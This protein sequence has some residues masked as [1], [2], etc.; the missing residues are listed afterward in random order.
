MRGCGAL[1]S[2]K[3]QKNIIPNGR[4]GW[5]YIEAPPLETLRTRAGP[6]CGRHD[7]QVALTVV[8]FSS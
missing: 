3:N 5:A 6:P 7:P 8:D 2:L 1:I 4:P